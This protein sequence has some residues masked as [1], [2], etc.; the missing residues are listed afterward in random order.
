[1]PDRPPWRYPPGRRD[2]AVAAAGGIAVCVGALMGIIVRR[3]NNRVGPARRSAVGAIGHRTSPVTFAAAMS[4]QDLPDATPQA[5]L[6]AAPLDEH[7]TR[8]TAGAIVHPLAPVAL[9]DGPAGTPFAQ[10]RPEFAGGETWLPVINQQPGWI[11]VL[12]PSRP[13]GATGWLEAARVRVA[14]S[15]HEVRVNLRAARLRLVHDGNSIGT[16]TISAG[17]IPAGRTFVLCDVRR[18]PQS[19]PVLLRLA[20]HARTDDPAPVTIHRSPT[21]RSE[22]D[23]RGCIRAPDT[24]MTALSAVGPGCLVRIYAR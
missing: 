1:M 6:P 15:R 14:Q 13:S 11:H 21:R 7:P 22:P 9:L 2:L 20:T 18:A 10:L 19:A 4:M 3:G 23:N 24:A 12:L 17:P 16:W 5:F 8:G